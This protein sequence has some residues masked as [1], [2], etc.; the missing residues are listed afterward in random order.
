MKTNLQELLKTVLERGLS[1]ATYIF[2]FLE[3]T[4]YFSSRVCYSSND[5]GLKVIYANYLYPLMLFYE[6]NVYL[7]FIAMVAVFL[8]CSRK[9]LPLTKFLRFNVLQAILLDIICA[10][11]GQ[12]YMACPTVFK[13]SPFGIMFANFIFLGTFCWIMYSILIISLGRFPVL[14]V[15]SRAANIHL[16]R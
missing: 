16:Q 7:I 4:V 14:P 10:C 13:L 15:I 12:I 6:K 1:I 8:M 9:S 11:V 3:I 2:P 5:I